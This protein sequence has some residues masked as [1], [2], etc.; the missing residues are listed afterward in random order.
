MMQCGRY[1]RD[2]IEPEVE[3]L[4]GWEQWLEQEGKQ[5]PTSKVYFAIC[6]SYFDLFV[7]YLIDFS[8]AAHAPPAYGEGWQASLV[9][10]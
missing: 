3:G 7:H 8:A 5:R 9:V 1:I 6:A 4:F 10:S 2:H